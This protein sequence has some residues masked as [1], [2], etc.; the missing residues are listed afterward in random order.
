MTNLQLFHWFRRWRRRPSWKMIM[1]LWFGDNRT[2]H[3]LFSLCTKFHR[4]RV[5]NDFS[6]AISLVFKMAASA[7]L[8]N[9]HRLAFLWNS[10]SACVVQSV[11]RNSLKSDHKWLFYR[12][13]SIFKMAASAILENDH[14]LP[15]LCYSNSACGVQF[16]YLTSSKSGHWSALR[17]GVPKSVSHW[18]AI[19]PITTCLE[20][21]VP[22]WQRHDSESYM[23]AWSK[24]SSGKD[25]WVELHGR[26]H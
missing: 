24:Y 2:R 20:L 19:S 10:N 9:D 3:V 15:V 6:K 17:G 22:C 12:H 26:Y 11:Y 1:D 8:E 5:I 13:W 14:E 21:Y 23:E 16:E 25:A 7:I 4:N 18:K